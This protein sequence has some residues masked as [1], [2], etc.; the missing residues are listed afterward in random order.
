MTQLQLGQQRR[1]KVMDHFESV[2]RWWLEEARQVAR[3]IALSRG[4][5]TSDD[6]KDVIGEPPEGLHHNIAGAIFRRG[7]EWE[8][9]G[10]V[11]SRRALNNASLISQ[12]RLRGT[13][14]VAVMHCAGCRC[15][16]DGNVTA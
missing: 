12:W 5:V 6:V 2:G 3:Q 15:N 7:K 1:E 13:S 9:V 10:M 4:V 16:R 8:W 14:A 11:P